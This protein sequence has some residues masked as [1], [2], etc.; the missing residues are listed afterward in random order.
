MWV[1][2]HPKEM[3][4]HSLGPSA[5][6]HSTLIN[7]KFY[8]RS[9]RPWKI[10]LL[11][12]K[13]NLFKMP[14]SI[15]MTQ[16]FVVFLAFCYFACLFLAFFI[17]YLIFES[18]QSDGPDDEGQI[19][20]IVRAGPFAQANWLPKPQARHAGPIRVNEI[21]YDAASYY[22]KTKIRTDHHNNHHQHQNHRSTNH[23]SRLHHPPSSPPIITVWRLQ[24]DDQLNLFD[25][26]ILYLYWYKQ[27][28]K[29]TENSII[30]S[31]HCRI[32]PRNM[33]TF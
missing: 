24:Q 2:Y 10:S 30:F 8:F 22:R 28:M 31:A 29:C 16:G 6:A 1:S 7:S 3:L 14:L 18:W 12:P 9:W 4:F 17:L 32:Y 33:A 19:E 26:Y 27:R 11:W 21:Q 15:S 23:V 13:K 5:L 25:Y 20:D